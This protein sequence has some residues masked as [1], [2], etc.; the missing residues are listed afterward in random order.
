MADTRRYDEHAVVLAYVDARRP[1]YPHQDFAV[2]RRQRLAALEAAYG[3]SMSMASARNA[4]AAPLWMLFDATV[5][6]Y[7]A[8]RGPRAGFLEDS[9][10]NTTLEKV[11]D[12]TAHVRETE[13]RLH[14]L[15][16]AARAAH[17]EMLHGLFLLIMGPIASPVS[18]A[19]L[20]RFGCDDSKEPVLSDYYD[21]M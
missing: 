9:L 19:D 7:L 21:D 3:F 6:S 2:F 5:D 11:D 15:L 10:I 13:A 8:L 1:P 18:S 4:K 16:Q 12:P 14:A 20:I 17:L